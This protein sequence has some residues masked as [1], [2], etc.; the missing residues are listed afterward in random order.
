M[1]APEN[2]IEWRGHNM[3]DRDGDKIGRIEEI[4]LD[5]E[6]DSPEWALV[7]TGLFGTRSTFVPLEGATVQ[8]D[9][10]QVPQEKGVVQD[11][12]GM[13][14]EGQLSQEE[15]EQLYR[16]YGLEYAPL[17]P[18]GG[19]GAERREAGPAEAM[20]GAPAGQAE[21]AQAQ[22]A[23]EEREAEPEE[24]EAEPESEEGDAGRPRMGFGEAA[25]V[26]EPT[27]GKPGT[28]VAGVDQPG[29]PPEGVARGAAGMPVSKDTVKLGTVRPGSG[30]AGRS[31]E[32]EP[33]I[34]PE[35]AGPEEPAATPLKEPPPTQADI[36]EGRTGERPA[37]DEQQ[38]G[39]AQRQPVQAE[40]PGREAGEGGARGL[41]LKRYVVVEV[42]QEVADGEPD[43]IQVEGRQASDPLPGAESPAKG[44]ERP[45]E[46]R[47]GG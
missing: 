12:P 28:S 4:F 16:Y 47:P 29:M 26:G 36:E 5:S 25:G 43:E 6:T 24:R 23:P 2:A 30:F 42:T 39:E 11:A 15:E 18:D 44:V 37:A 13:E 1:P 40:Q 46:G 38:P 8:G 45:E 7:R 20:E 17:G 9:T 10:V 35:A 33:G 34:G 14:R 19:V 3:V 22:A 27:P 41:R 31:E 21:R 32:G